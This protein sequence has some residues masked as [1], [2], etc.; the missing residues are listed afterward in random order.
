MG[1][2]S[3]D[4][5]ARILEVSRDLFFSKGFHETS[6][7]EI[8]KAVGISSGAIYKHFD[9]KE[10]I[11]YEIVEP[12]VSNWWKVCDSETAIFKENIIRFKKNEIG[13]EQLAN[14]EAI[15]KFIFLYSKGTKYEYFLDEL[16]EWEYNITIDMLNLIYE[17]KEYFKFASEKEFKY[18]IRTSFEAVFYTFKLDIEKKERR[19]IIK[20]LHNIYTP[21][22]NDIFS[23]SFN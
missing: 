16:V 8:A 14:N 17:D 22:W 23:K 2:A 19:R 10:N 4:T 11:L 1:R 15:W 9:N 3:S 7:R 20:I 12:H 5:K 13:F 21:Y 6:I 18:I